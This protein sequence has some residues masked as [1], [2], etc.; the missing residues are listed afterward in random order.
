MTGTAGTCS[1]NSRLE[2]ASIH[3]D[4]G[5]YF[6]FDHRLACAG[7]IV[8]WYYCYYADTLADYASAYWIRFQ[9]WREIENTRLLHIHSYHVHLETLPSNESFVCQREVVSEPIAVEVGDF[10]GVNLPVRI[11]NPI[12]VIG[13]GL[14]GSVLYRNNG[15]LSFIHLDREEDLVL[16]VDAEIGLYIIIHNRVCGV[17]IHSLCR[18][19]I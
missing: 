9:V 15:N 11:A 13:Q 17:S 16:H 2:K 3:Q 5:H 19:Y 8:S 18:A 10:L 14:P 6:D 7:N 1:F 4:P 12:P